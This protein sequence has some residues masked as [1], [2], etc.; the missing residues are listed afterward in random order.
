[1]LLFSTLD[2]FSAGFGIPPLLFF[3]II[4]IFPYLP[5]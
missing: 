3:A 4:A 1:V 5:I 2:S